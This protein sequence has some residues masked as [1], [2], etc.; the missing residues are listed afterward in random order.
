MPW[1]VLNCPVLCCPGLSC[2][3]VGEAVS[4]EKAWGNRNSVMYKRSFPCD[5]ETCEEKEVTYTFPDSPGKKWSGREHR[6]SKIAQMHLLIILY[7]LPGSANAG[8]FTAWIDPYHSVKSNARFA[9]ELSASAKVDHAACDVSEPSTLAAIFAQ[10]F[11]FFV[12]SWFSSSSTSSSSQ[13]RTQDS[14]RQVLLV[15]GILLLALIVIIVIVIIIANRSGYTTA[16]A[17]ET[18]SYNE[19]NDYNDYSGNWWGRIEA[20]ELYNLVSP[21]CPNRTPSAQNSRRTSEFFKGFSHQFWEWRT[22]PPPVW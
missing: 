3:I 16:Q 14:R 9:H 10:Q 20:T 6:T 15:V 22:I 1:C 8:K 5:E 11:Q 18:S 13:S 2:C 21:W 19:Y 12:G 17:S 4:M 7:R